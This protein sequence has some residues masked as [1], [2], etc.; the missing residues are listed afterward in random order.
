MNMSDQKQ[1]VS[2][3]SNKSEQKQEHTFTRNGNGMDTK[4]KKA[5]HVLQTKGEKEFIKHI[6]TGNDGERLSYAEMRARYG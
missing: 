1:S 5:L 2:S 4:N 3:T 6:F